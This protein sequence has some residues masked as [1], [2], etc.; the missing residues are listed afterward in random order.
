MLV[1]HWIFFMS[2]SVYLLSLQLKDDG[3]FLMTSMEMFSKCCTM[4]IWRLDKHYIHRTLPSVVYVCR[5]G[6]HSHSREQCTRCRPQ[7]RR[8]RASLIESLCEWRV[9]DFMDLIQPYREIVATLLTL[10]ISKPL[11]SYLFP[12]ISGKFTKKEWVWLWV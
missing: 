12:D 8:G 9:G 6:K 2:L 3:Y 1:P 7:W 10:I 5:I 4:M 11:E